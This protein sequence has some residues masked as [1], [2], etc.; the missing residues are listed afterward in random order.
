MTKKKF[1]L[2]DAIRK[3]WLKESLEEFIETTEESISELLAAPIIMGHLTADGKASV[4]FSFGES[5]CGPKGCRDFFT[6]SSTWT[7]F[8]KTF[9]N[10]DRPKDWIPHI[11]KLL[12][13]LQ[14]SKR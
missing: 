10:C 7:E 13:K 12:R 1:K 5:F 6:S 3:K 9:T 14:R 4:S 11:E 2:G 8:C